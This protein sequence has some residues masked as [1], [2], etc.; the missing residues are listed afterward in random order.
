MRP[1]FKNKLHCLNRCSLTPSTV[2][3]SRIDRLVNLFVRTHPT[4]VSGYRS[5]R[6]IVDRAAT[7]TT[8]TTGR[9]SAN[10]TAVLIEVSERSNP[11]SPRRAP[12][13]K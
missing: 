4:F 11:A 1:T 10:D 5:V 13:I 12:G 2:L 6:V 7:R 9:S 8:K 3:T